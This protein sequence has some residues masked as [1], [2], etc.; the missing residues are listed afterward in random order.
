MRKYFFRTFSSFSVQLFWCIFSTAI[1]LLVVGLLILNNYSAKTAVKMDN[2]RMEESL[3]ITANNI[4][5]SLNEVDNI[6]YTFFAQNNVLKLTKQPCDYP[7][8][9]YNDIRNAIIRTE[10]T[11]PNISDM[12]YC[13][14]WGNLFSAYIEPSQGNNVLFVD[15]DS[16]REFLSTLETYTIDVNETWYFLVPSLSGISNHAFANVRNIN[17]SVNDV[18]P[19]LIIYYSEKTLCSL[20]CFLGE[21][22]FI[23]T[24]SGTIVSAVDKAKLGEIVDEKVCN[25]IT[26]TQKP[27]SFV[28]QGKRYHASFCPVINCYLVVPSDSAVLTQVNRSTAIV[29]MVI[30]LAG[31]FLSIIWSR[32]IAYSMTRPLVSLKQIMEQVQDGDLTVRGYTER[33]DE[34]GFLYSSFNYMM[35]MVNQYLEQHKQQYRLAQIAELQLMQAQINPHLLYNSLDSALYLMS[36]DHSELS[37]QVL[38]EL[39]HYFR[40]SLQKGSRIV[41]VGSAIE[42]VKTYLRLQN[43]CRMKEYQLEIKGDLS[44]LDVDILHM[45]MQPIVENSV[46]HGLEGSYTDGVIEIFLSRDENDVLIRIQDNGMGMDDLQLEN[47]QNR[48]YSTNLVDGG[49][50]LWNVAQRI[51]IHYGDSYGLTVESELGEYTAVTLRIPDASAHVTE[52]KNN[53]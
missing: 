7:S 38:E 34:I 53:V 5:T 17:L 51:R 14:K 25:Q 11:S 50:G 13:D 33:S 48:L 1:V 19:I 2:E 36:S 10:N 23:M 32:L 16:C 29:T 42:L 41:K 4:A 9:A 28:L 20:Y 30:L 47:L 8:N 37:C 45:C 31:I 3:R 6:A 43:L 18:N 15:L 24:D 26:E 39:S 27:I 35:D 22:S 40:L 44:V 52:D 12:V 46:L 49:Y 21:E